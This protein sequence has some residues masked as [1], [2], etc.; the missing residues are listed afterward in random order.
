M[1]AIAE[2][3]RLLGAPDCGC[4][5]ILVDAR[6]EVD[7]GT[8]EKAFRGPQLLVDVVHRGAAI[9]GDVA[10]GIEARGAVADELHHR[11]AHER[12]AARD[13]NPFFPALVL[14]VQR[15]RR[16][17]H[18]HP[19]VTAN[20]Q[21]QVAHGV[22]RARP[23]FLIRLSSSCS[24]SSVARISR[25]GPG[26]CERRWR[27]RYDGACNEYAIHHFHKLVHEALNGRC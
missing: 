11:E 8:G 14:V 9:T 16:K 4:S 19:P 3:R 6:L 10:G 23:P 18:D 5:Q 20:G 21:V 2:R 24:S 15:N 17:L 27:K 7:V 22:R 1:P 12:L 25:D 26:P 13:V